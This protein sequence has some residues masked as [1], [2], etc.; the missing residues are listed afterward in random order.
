MAVDYSKMIP[1]P[2]KLAEIVA[3][4]R[5]NGSVYVD[6]RSAGDPLLLT[7]IERNKGLGLQM[8]LHPVEMDEIAKLF[9]GGMRVTVTADTDM[10]VR[11]DALELI[12]LAAAYG[13]SDMHIM[14]RGKHSEIQI[15]VKGGLRVLA[16]KT[17]EEGQTL[18]RAIYQGIAQTRDSSFNELDFQ[19][20]QVP[21][22][23]FSLDVGLTS[24]RIV[25][26][27]CY[28]QALG[29]Q[30]MTLRLQYSGAQSIK[31]GRTLPALELPRRPDGALRLLQMGYTVGQVEKI[32]T[33]MDAPNG[34]VIFTGPTGSGKTTAMFEALKEG[35]RVKPQRRLVTVEDPVEYPMEWAVQMAVTGAKNDAETGAAFGERV[36]V[37]LRMAPNVILLG[38]LRGPDVAV[39]A[40][41]AAVTG[42]QVWTTMHVTDP[43]LFV[44][45]LELMDRQ[46]LERRVFC[47]HKVVRGVISQRL[48]PTLCP[49]CSVALNVALSANPKALSRR[50][51]DALETWGDTQHVR[52]TGPGCAHC[53]NDGVIGRFAV[54]E[55]VITDAELMR[56]FVA[57]GSETARVNYRKKQGSDPSMLESAIAQVLTGTVDPTAVEDFVDLIERCERRERRSN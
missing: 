7:W 39:A 31:K 33:L 3:V 27:P 50:I 23:G 8:S 16:R 32:R 30:F 14:L 20:A 5:S 29:G 6:K 11:A 56:D 18:I 36:R 46:R 38:E 9:E 10:L 34:V 47:D 54:A 1:V 2:V 4:D 12:E 24:V 15:V 48:L 41:E 25:R 21:G 44:D 52:L 17:Q 49:K 35:A 26:G 13:A 19:N 28:P 22:E 43:F 37:A 53:G 45:R 55:V 42:H 51:R 57:H 40:L